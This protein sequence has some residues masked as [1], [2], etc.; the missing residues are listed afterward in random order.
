MASVTDWYLLMFA[1]LGV[2]TPVVNSQS[3]EEWIKQGKDELEKYLKLE[4]NTNTAKNVILFLGDGMGIATVT[5]ARIYKGQLAGQTGEEFVLGFEGLPRAGLIKTY[6][7]DFQVPDS[8]G[9]ATAILSGVK[10]NRGVIGYDYSVKRT[11]CGSV[12][13]E[14]K[15]ESIFDL[16]VKEGKSTGI[17]STK[18]ITNASPASVYAHTPERNWEAIGLGGCQDIASQFLDKSLDFQVVL[19]GGRKYM[20]PLSETDPE[21]ANSRGRRLDRRNLIDE[22]IERIPDGVHA[23]YVWNQEQFD[24][25]DTDSTDYLLG[26]FAYEEMQFECRRHND[27]AGEPS[28]SE[29]VDKAIKI[30]Q[31]NENGYLLFVEGGL[32]DTAHHDNWAYGAIT[33]TVAFDDAVEKALDMVNTEDTLVIVTADHGHVNTVNGYPYRGNPI[34]GVTSDVLESFDGLPYTT[35]SY[36][37]G[38]GAV[39]VAASYRINGTRPD[40]SLQDTEAQNYIQQSLVPAHRE[41]HGGEDVS[42]HADGPYSHLFQ[43]VHEQTYIAHVIKYAARLGEYATHR[44]NG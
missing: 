28:I 27:T 37:N 40:I 4:Q 23:E 34:L 15:L 8:A 16:A 11:D 2:I 42:I 24:N 1:V 44:S 41:S 25:V 36:A 17:I 7:T 5:S 39:A 12:T 43:G 26:L 10:T 29:M 31:K 20:L 32:I 35:I 21:N 22:W 30:L 14:A 9:T 3:A 18:S 6:N 33:D 38:P 19:G 13:E